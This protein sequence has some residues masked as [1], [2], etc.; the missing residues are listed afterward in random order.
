LRELGTIAPDQL[1]WRRCGGF[2]KLY[3]GVTS[4]V[5]TAETIKPP[6]HFV[7]EIRTAT[8]SGTPALTSCESRSAANRERLN[9]YTDA[10]VA[11]I[12]VW[13]SLSLDILTC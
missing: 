13:Q 2:H 11:G 6:P 7:P 5:E 8:H 3:G 1:V 10:E 9:H 12:A 4:A